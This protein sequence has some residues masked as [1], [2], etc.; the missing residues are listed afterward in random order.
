MT[1]SECIR[2]AVL[3]QIVTEYGLNAYAEAVEEHKKN[4]KAYALDAVIADYGKKD[5]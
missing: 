3:E 2:R 1:V 4:P 5:I